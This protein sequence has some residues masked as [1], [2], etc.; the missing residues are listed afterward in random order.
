MKGGREIY[1]KM[2]QID[3]SEHKNMILEIK[4]ICQMLNT[5]NEKTHIKVQVSD[6]L[7]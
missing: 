2:M 3:F 4:K 7:E 1:L 5:M 6:I